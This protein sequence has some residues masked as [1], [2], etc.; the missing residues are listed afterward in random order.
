MPFINLR[1]EDG[2]L[3]EELPLSIGKGEEVEVV[4]DIRIGLPEGYTPDFIK[5]DILKL[6]PGISGF[7]D[8]SVV[9]GDGEFRV[10]IIG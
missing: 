7:K 3:I 8:G 1:Y 6:M 2:K 10:T 9:I 5:T 4:V